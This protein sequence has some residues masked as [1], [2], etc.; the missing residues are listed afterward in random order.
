M[1]LM[2]L[3]DSN[4]IDLFDYGELDWG[5]GDPLVVVDKLG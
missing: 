3:I 4:L 5:E 2:V 1:I